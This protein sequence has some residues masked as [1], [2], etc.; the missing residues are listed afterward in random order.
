[1][2]GRSAELA[3]VRDGL[4]RGQIVQIVGPPG[5]GKSTL[6]QRAVDGRT[7]AWV[8]L[9]SVA[10][11]RLEDAI[12][13]E[14]GVPSGRDGLV[15]ALRDVQVLVLDG[16]EGVTQGLP[17]LL[18][19]LGPAAALVTTRRRMASGV[20]VELGPLPAA[21]A[22]EVFRSRARTVGAGE[23]VEREG[24]AVAALVERLEGWPLALELAASRMRVYS[25]A[26]LLD[27][28]TLPV[29]TDQT[30]GGRHGSLSDA[31]Q[32]SWALLEP[33]DRTALAA[34][35]RFR[36]PFDRAGFRAVA[37]AGLDALER[38][39]DA[40]LVQW[41]AV[42]GARRYQVLAP[43][44]EFALERNDDAGAAERYATH[45][46]AGA[47]SAAADAETSKAAEARAE[48]SRLTPDLEALL[49]HPPA[50]AARA[51]LAL[52]VLA[53]ARGP[54]QTAVEWLAAIPRDGV[55]LETAQALDL[56]QADLGIR[57]FQG[58]APLALL[59][60]LPESTLT[61]RHRGLAYLR[62]RDVEA[63]VTWLDRARRSAEAEGDR[64][65]Q[66]Q[67]LLSLGVA[68][69]QAGR[70]STA[71]AALREARAHVEHVDAPDLE[72]MTLKFLCSTERDL[73]APVPSRIGWVE[74]AV[75]LHRRSGNLRLEAMALNV[76]AIT[77][78]DGDDPRAEAI[79]AEGAHIAE[80]AGLR[81]TVDQ[82]KLLRALDRLGRLDLDGAEA[83]LVKLDQPDVHPWMHNWR[84]VLEGIVA[85]HRGNRDLAV[86]LAREAVEGAVASELQGDAVLF[87]CVLALL[88]E[89]EPPEPL[90][91]LPPNAPMRMLCELAAQVRRG[92]PVASAQ[93][94]AAHGFVEAR[95]F[96]SVTAGGSGTEVAADGSWF[97][98]RGEARVDLR[99]RRVLRRVLAALVRRRAEPITHEELLAEGWP[100]ERPTAASGR[101]RVHVAVADLRRL[102]LRDAIQTVENDGRTAYK[103]V[104]TARG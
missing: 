58:D 60:G 16:A 8:P 7:A 26:E 42:A 41:S 13:R 33:G 66:T 80:R 90:E 83:E 95:V 6:A 93:L 3:L 61:L 104:A 96:L 98:V 47:E 2:I 15:S 39:M 35:A 101:A 37:G 78:L 36:G 85:L 94:R 79:M 1:M 99:R 92:E 75:A 77:L 56:A 11:D 86:L 21:E 69:L 44:R 53:R 57:M 76:L 84:H 54:L 22:V 102:G 97:Q 40:S 63:A 5:I 28:P 30:R 55:P 67:A 87:G 38:L 25:P 82:M 50:T 20:T 10:P 100:G 29:L 48:L 59:A 68:H 70:T 49:D 9:E 27:E 72:G 23:V 71:A 52:A 64:Y 17:E 51:A 24:A 45:V 74:R 43:I 81:S 65:E 32:A 34:I 12:A 46:L 103:L 14:L 18:D 91:V 62:A 4:D 89:G 88:G 31:L 19:A 73:G